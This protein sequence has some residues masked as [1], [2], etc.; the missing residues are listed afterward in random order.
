MNYNLKPKENISRNN[1]NNNNNN[2]NNNNSVQL[3]PYLVLFITTLHVV[4]STSY[5]DFH[6]DLAHYTVG[7]VIQMESLG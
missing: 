1:D 2:N 6:G 3:N 4:S 7:N 5:I